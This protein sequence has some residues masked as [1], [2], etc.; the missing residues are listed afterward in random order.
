MATSGR[1]VLA[2]TSCYVLLTGETLTTN[3]PTTPRGKIHLSFGGRVRQASY[4]LSKWKSLGFTVRERHTWP[5]RG[6]SMWHCTAQKG[7]HEMKMKDEA[8]KEET[9]NEHS[10]LCRLNG[11]WYQWAYLRLDGTPHLWWNHW[12]PPLRPIFH[13]TMTAFSSGLM[14]VIL[15]FIYRLR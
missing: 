1:L 7:F 12:N 10:S 11:L 8:G 14:N 9:R 13:G 2:F 15:L 3:W 5:L 6:G 4:S